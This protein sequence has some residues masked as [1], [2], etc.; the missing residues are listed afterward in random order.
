MLSYLT[1]YHSSI[2]ELA[3]SIVYEQYFSGVVDVIRR[4]HYGLLALYQG[5][6]TYTRSYRGRK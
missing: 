6:L 3:L 1:E 4:P 2:S 5:S